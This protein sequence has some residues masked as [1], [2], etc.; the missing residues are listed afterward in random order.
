MDNYKDTPN[1]KMSSKCFIDLFS[2]ILDINCEYVNI[3]SNGKF[4]TFRGFDNNEKEIY[5]KQCNDP[6]DSNDDFVLRISKSSLES[7]YKNIPKDEISCFYLEKDKPIKIE[8]YNK[9]Y[10]FYV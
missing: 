4:I 9:T 6:L 10:Q 5:V 8:T 1:I 2:E 3:E 7:L